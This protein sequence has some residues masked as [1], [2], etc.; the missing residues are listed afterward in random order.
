MGDLF[1]VETLHFGMWYQ[2]RTRIVENDFNPSYVQQEE[3][4]D[5]WT[6][7]VDADGTLKF[8]RAASLIILVVGGLLGIILWFRPCLVGRITKLSWFAIAVVYMAF[9]TPL[10]AL[11]FL[12]FRSNACTDNPVVAS[13]E[14]TLNREDLYETKCSWDQASTANVFATFLWFSTGVAMIYVGEPLNPQPGPPE[15]QTVTYERTDMPDGTVSVNK[16]AVVKGTS[17]DIPTK[18]V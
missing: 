18:E 12:L 6:T 2:K 5:E 7:D 9:I 14:E 11:T 1:E 4:C 16:V 13:I 17:V 10:Q 15:V 8:V 3:T